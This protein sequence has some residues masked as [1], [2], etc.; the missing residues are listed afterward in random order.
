MHW[1][2]YFADGR[3]FSDADGHPHESP[4][5]YALVIVQRDDRCGRVLI[6]GFDWYVLDS[7]GQWH[8]CPERADVDEY[9]L[10]LPARCVRVIKGFGVPD[11]AFADVMRRAKADPDFPPKSATRASEKP[12]NRSC[13][14]VTERD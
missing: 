10:D 11:P 14:P 2:I 1:R 3:T 6:H 4:G 12:G 5:R 8:G 13:S 9:M 7:A